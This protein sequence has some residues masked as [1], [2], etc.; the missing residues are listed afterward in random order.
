[1]HAL[2]T[3][4]GYIIATLLILLMV[5]TDGSHFG[6]AFQFPD[7]IRA[8][9]FLAGFY[10]ASPWF[11]LLLL[12]VAGGGDYINITYG[13]VSDWCVSPTYVM[14]VPAYALLWFG[15]RWC[16][17]KDLQG[18]KQ[19]LLCAGALAITTTI[20]SQLT[21]GS[22]YFFSGRYPDPTWA[23]YGLRVVKYFPSYIGYAFLYSAFAACIH[24]A[25]ITLL[26]RQ[27]TTAQSHK[28]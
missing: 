28:A 12:A 15:G 17:Q 21:S 23:E 7:A 11:L 19:L 18:I 14:L 13:G 16:A 20:A 24:I 8:V 2:N 27:N 3:K 6:T 22:F 5:V 10:I 4:P 26:R 9:F 25:V 1:M